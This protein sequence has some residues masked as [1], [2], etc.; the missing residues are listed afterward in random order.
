MP[1]NKIKFGGRLA[2]ILTCVIN[3]LGSV[4]LYTRDIQIPV[5]TALAT[6]AENL[7]SVLGGWAGPKPRKTWVP[8]TEA[9]IG[10]RAAAKVDESGAFRF[11]NWTIH[12][13]ASPGLLFTDCDGCAHRDRIFLNILISQ[14]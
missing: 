13:H 8:W 12:P 5:H 7:G 4:I 2:S 10:P 3:L 9:V 11:V 14:K 6:D 1:P